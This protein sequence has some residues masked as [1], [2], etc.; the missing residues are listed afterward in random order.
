MVEKQEVETPRPHSALEMVCYESEMTG[1]SQCRQ[2]L[3]EGF[4]IVTRWG[5]YIKMTME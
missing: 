1:K 3:Q 2:N 5:I 4:Q